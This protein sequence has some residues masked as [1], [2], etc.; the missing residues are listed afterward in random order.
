MFI[1]TSPT[2]LLQ[3]FMLLNFLY[4]V[5]LQLDKHTEEELSVWRC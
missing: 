1:I 4:K 3:C 2:L 5:P